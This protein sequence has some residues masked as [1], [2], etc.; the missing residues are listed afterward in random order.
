[1]MCSAIHNPATCEIRA[2]VRLLHAKNVNAAEIHR[3]FCAVYG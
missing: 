1:M 3:E 2:F